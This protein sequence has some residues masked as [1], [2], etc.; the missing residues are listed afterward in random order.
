MTDTLTRPAENISSIHGRKPRLG[1]LGVGW[2]GLNRMEAVA[3]SG[4]GEIAAICDTSDQVL[5]RSLSS[6]PGAAAVRSFDELL[7]ADLDGL[8]IATPSAQ[9]S[10][11]S[12][13]ALERGLHVFC[14]KSLART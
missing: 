4:L 2:I 5:E 12:I 10:E 8:V 13:R 6:A 7:E 1:F 3:R 9:H 14:Q 11:Q